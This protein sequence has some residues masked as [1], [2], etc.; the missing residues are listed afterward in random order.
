MENRAV[1]A[2]TRWM[3]NN[4]ATWDG[5]HLG[6]IVVNY[7]AY[8][9][10]TQV[11]DADTDYTGVSDEPIRFKLVQTAAGGTYYINDAEVATD[12][13][14][15]TYVGPVSIYLH[16]GR[17]TFTAPSRAQHEVLSFKLISDG[18]VVYHG[19][20]TPPPPAPPA[21]PPA[22]VVD[23]SAPVLVGTVGAARAR[24]RLSTPT[25]RRDI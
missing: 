24:T 11:S 20:S 18:E 12:P 5:F 8:D 14:V 19:V 4:Y 6:S 23:P 2:W 25:G 15:L 7:D 1:L 13:I 3:F 16:D 10:G 9:M 17:S 21:P 22:F